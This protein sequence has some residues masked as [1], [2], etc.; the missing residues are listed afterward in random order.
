MDTK[1]RSDAPRR[2]RA[3]KPQPKYTAP[4]VVYSQPAPFNR[5]ALIL[6]LVT[7]LAVVIAIV[8]GL[9]IFFKIETIT[10]EGTD[11]YSPWSVSQASGLESGDSLLFFGRA[12]AAGNIIQQLPYI[13]TV[14]FQITLP[15][16]VNILVEESPMAYC[17]EDTQGNWWY[18]TSQGRLIEQVSSADA[19]V[20]KG[21]QITS[22]VAGEMA[23]AAEDQSG[24]TT[25]AD[26]LRAALEICCLLEENEILGQAASVDVSKLQGVEVWYGDQYQIELGDTQRLDYKITA[27]C[28]AIRQMS[29]YQRGVLDASFTTFPDRVG[30][31]PFTE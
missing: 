24:L 28:Q 6:R 8:M 13:K 19:T 15:G 27:A 11:K 1:D 21:L 22:P 23:T 14:R 7:I 16:T 10:V 18:M 12:G 31:M 9:S 26:R 29:S 5:R 2:R 4:E 30:Y 20:I 17:V 25:G 3:P